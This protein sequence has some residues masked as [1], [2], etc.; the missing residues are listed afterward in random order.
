MSRTTRLGVG[1]LAWGGLAYGV[2]SLRHLPGDYTHPF[3]GPWGCLPPLQ[4]LAA[5]HGFWA[6]ALAP[7]V[8]WTARTLPPGRLRGLGTSLVAF[9]ALALGILVGRELLTLP[10]GAATELRQYLPQRAVFAVAMLTDVPLVQIVVA[11]AICRGVG[12][13]RGG[14]IPPSHAEVPG[15]PARSGQRRSQAVPNLAR[16]TGPGRI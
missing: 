1:V 8:I 16:M 6:L 9:G 11:G 2:L 7:P 15:G 14:R 5:V 3:C 12:R 4:A 13:R 10:P